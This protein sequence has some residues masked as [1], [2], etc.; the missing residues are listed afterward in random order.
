M[1]PQD[2]ARLAADGNR[3]IPTRVQVD[4][5]LTRGRAINNGAGFDSLPADLDEAVAVSRDRFK[6]ETMNEIAD[7]PRNM[8][9]RTSDVIRDR[10]KREL[11]VNG[12]FY[13]DNEKAALRKVAN[14]PVTVALET[15]GRLAPSL[16]TRGGAASAVIQ[17]MGFVGAPGP[18][19]AVS[20]AGILGTLGAK[21]AANRRARSD[22]NAATSYMQG[23]DLDAIIAAEQQNAALSYL[24]GAQGG[25]ASAND[26]RKDR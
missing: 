9:G 14:G 1:S 18:L 17:G 12:R 20:V 6:T 25:V 19:K 11:E 22:L 13:T 26:R 21:S 4:E 24:R 16:E 2:V 3:A 23:F 7:I 10:I 15:I 8:R 5:I